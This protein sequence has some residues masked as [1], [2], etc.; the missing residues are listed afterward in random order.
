MATAIIDDTDAETSLLAFAEC[1][2]GLNL[3]D[4]QCDAIEP[5][6]HA[7]EEM[8]MVSLATPNGSGKSAVVI[9]TLILGWLYLYPKGRVVLTTADGKQLDGQVMPAINAHRSKF[10]NWKFIE[11]HITT[12]TGGHF[13][14]F[15]TDEPGRAEGWHKLNDH[16]GPLLII[17]DEAKSVAEGIFDGIDRC[18]FNGLLLASSPGKMSGT[19]YDSQ[20]EENQGFIRV[21]VGLKDCPHITQ[22][23]IDRIIAKHG[24]NSPFTRS[25]LHGEFLESYDGKP[26]YYAYNQ[27][28]HEGE[29]LPW[30]SGAYLWRGHDVGTFAAT[31][32]SAYWVENGREYWHDLFEFYAEGFDADRQAREVLRITN[33]EF[34]FWNDRQICAG[35]HDAIDPA[36]ANSSYTRQINVNGKS[37]N[38]SA[39]NI[40]RTYNINPVYRTS[41][42]GLVETIA[43]VNRLFEKRDGLGRPVFRVDRKGC[44]KLVRGYR[45]AYRWP[46]EAEKGANSNVPLKGVDCDQLDHPQDAARYSKINALK[47]LRGEIEAAAAPVPYRVERRNINRLRAV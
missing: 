34:P 7:S 23:K 24:A 32:W 37:V 1:V 46:T 33:D 43:V 27:D 47:L 30:P 20:M 4:W 3:Y 6:D 44:P 17:V 25:A 26:V 41:A 10:P 12:D 21:R 8:T 29:D 19:F 22:D 45:G 35:V 11:R 39:L 18:T 28:I 15:T 13:D 31:T 5:F 14:A 36:A 2:L 40:F 38:E 9:P 16:E 42:R